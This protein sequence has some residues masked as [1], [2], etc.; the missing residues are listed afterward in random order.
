MNMGA[1]AANTVL[2]RVSP[3]QSAAVIYHAGMRN[4]YNFLK[5]P[6]GADGDVMNNDAQ[7][8]INSVEKG[9]R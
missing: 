6:R 9:L 1:R 7:G 2:P 4:S 3:L 5:N 8:N